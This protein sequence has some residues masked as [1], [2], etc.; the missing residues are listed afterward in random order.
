MFQVKFKL[1][2]T[3]TATLALIGL[4]FP[5]TKAFAQDVTAPN[6]TY[7][8]TPPSPNGKN[9]WY[10]T[11]VQFN[12]QSTDLESGVKEINYRLDSGTW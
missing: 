10:V 9:S 11:P 7:T 2:L 6:T 5:A 12:I 4:L 3:A 1:I 8:Q